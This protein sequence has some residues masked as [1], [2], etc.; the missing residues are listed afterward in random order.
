[1]SFTPFMG[2]KDRSFLRVWQAVQYELGYSCRVLGT[3]PCSYACEEYLQGYADAREDMA[4]TEKIAFSKFL[5][6]RIAAARLVK[7]QSTEGV[8]A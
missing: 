8:A 7:K 3:I 5:E 2:R 4:S 6:S 1:M